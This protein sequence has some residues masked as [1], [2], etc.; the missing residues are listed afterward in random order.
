MAGGSADPTSPRRQ[1]GLTCYTVTDRQ[2]RVISHIYSTLTRPG[3]L[4]R[5]LRLRRCGLLALAAVAATLA[6]PAQAAAQQPDGAY[7]DV[8]DGAYYAES[9]TS[10]AGDGV[11][12]GTECGDAMFCPDQA[13]DRATMAVWLV[14]TVDSDDPTG[15]DDASFADA[16]FTDIG[17]HPDLYVDH[18]NRLAWLGITRGCAAAA[19][20]PNDSV[21]RAQMA[22]F[23]ARAFELP[24]PESP[25]SRFSD[26]ASDHAFAGHIAQ[27]AAARVTAGCGDGTRYCPNDTVTR[28]QMATFLARADGRVQLPQPPA[29]PDSGDA[30]GSVGVVCADESSPAGGPEELMVSGIDITEWVEWAIEAGAL[31]AGGKQVDR[32]IVG[33]ELAMWALVNELRESV[34][35]E[36]L[37]YDVHM[38]SVA[39]RW[40]QTMASTGNFVHNPNYVE[41]IGR[42]RSWRENIAANGIRLTGGCLE[43]EHLLAATVTAF[44]NLVDSPGHYANMIAPVGHGDPPPTALGVG[45]AITGHRLYLTQNFAQYRCGYDEVDIQS[46]RSMCRAT[47]PDS[48]LP[49]TDSESVGTYT[50]IATGY[51]HACAITTDDTIACWGDN[52]HGQADAPKGRYTAI[53]GAR[54]HSCA[55]K[56][57]DQTIACW[58]DDYREGTDSPKGRYT[59]ISANLW[60]SCAIKTDQTIACWGDNGAGQADAPQGQYTAIAAGWSHSCAIKSDKTIACWGDSDD[61]RTEAP[62]GQ[63]TAI[64]ADAWHSCAIKTDKTIA[65]WGHNDYGRADA[66]QGKYTAIATGFDYSCAIKTDGT[67]ACWGNNQ[68]GQA[69]APQGR[70][71]A[72][73]SGGYHSCAIKPDG[74]VACWGD[75]THYGQADAPGG[76]YTAIAAGVTHSCAIKTDETIACWGDNRQG[77]ADAPEGRYTAIATGLAHSCAIKT[78]GAVACWGSHFSGQTAAPQGRY[79]AIA[80]GHW[81]SCAIKTDQTIACW[82]NNGVG[83]TAAPQGRYTAIASG[84]NKSC[85]ITADDQTITCWGRYFSGQPDVPEGRYT[86]IAINSNHS[87][88]IRTDQAITCWG[89]HELSNLFGW[90]DAPAGRYTAIASGGGHSCAIKTDS[91]VACWGA[92]RYGQANA[93]AGRYAAIAAG[94]AHSCAV[95]TNQ[96]IACWNWTTN[97]PAGVSWLTRT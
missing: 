74:T 13:I 22:A 93:P 56:A 39:R 58:S 64:A 14:R 65:C 12:S 10:L 20:C 95:R 43:W 41:Q 48:G 88:G 24:E 33:A 16:G 79:T 50:A 89:N 42:G 51:F 4:N 55:I 85:A 62:K 25:A 40:S 90:V 54:Q 80:T 27:L 60:H 59:A 11:F 86:A 97:L 17:D 67:V 35:R 15:V 94:E 37:S 26:V 81:H 63:Y 72:I 18:I 23:I 32:L 57:D 3:G 69:D 21:T 31:D 36:P 77:R 96:T 30:V 8:D 1:T 82:G 29:E 9:V 92:N 53:A 84:G 52:R 6:A 49:P 71:T 45:I 44:E 5:R 2:F 83:Q 87:C 78:D 73:A 91:T 75:D 47:Q 46:M 70:Y 66:P 7:H 61:G 28:A 38:G 34:G 19:Y 76:K 68:Y